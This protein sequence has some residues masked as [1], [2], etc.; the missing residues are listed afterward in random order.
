MWHASLSLPRAA[1]PLVTTKWTRQQ[2]N[3][4][5]RQARQLLEGVGGAVEEVGLYPFAFHLRRGLSDPEIA[6][7]DRAWCA[8][9]ATDPAGT[10]EEVWAMFREAGLV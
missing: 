2:R 9:P 6:G 4:A 1:R 7:L 5:A 10:P 3:E 8:L